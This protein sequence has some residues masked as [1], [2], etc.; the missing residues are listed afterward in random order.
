LLLPY[1]VDSSC[2]TMRICGILD[3]VLITLEQL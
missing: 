1:I 3:H 2:K